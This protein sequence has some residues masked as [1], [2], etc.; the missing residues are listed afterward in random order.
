M[1]WLIVASII[2]SFSP[3]FLKML[4]T[5]VD[6]FLLGVVRLVLA[7]GFSLLACFILRV[8]WRKSTELAWE[9]KKRWVMVGFFQVGL[10]YAPY[11]LA[12][13]YLKGYEAALFTMTTPIYVVAINMVRERFFSRRLV[14]AACLAVVG[15]LVVAWKGLDSSGLLTGVLLVQAS[16][17]LFAFGQSLIAQEK[18]TSLGDYVSTTPYYFAGGLLGTTL[19]LC[20]SGL[21]TSWPEW[22]ISSQDWMVLAWLGIVA[23]GLGFLM[24][25]RGVQSVST[26]VL[27]VMSDLKLPISI[28]VSII[29]FSEQASFLRLTIGTLLMIIALIVIRQSHAGRDH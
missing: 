19:S 22:T 21:L 26:G 4:S 9:S 20:V 11:L 29:V 8:I 13:K 23:S 15:G 14:L 3:G 10:M 2:W 5:K 6:P 18:I 12:F 1:G 28:V 27:A 16:N 7:L 17:I 24:W 25:N